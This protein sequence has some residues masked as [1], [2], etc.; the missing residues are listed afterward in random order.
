M[1]NFLTS[2]LLALI[3]LALAG[4]GVWLIALGGSWYYADRKS[5]V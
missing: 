3:G 1:L 5:V 4:G 2:G